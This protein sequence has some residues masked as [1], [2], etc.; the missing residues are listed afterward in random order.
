MRA[1]GGDG[2]IGGKDGAAEQRRRAAWRGAGRVVLIQTSGREEV[3]C[4]AIRGAFL[5]CSKS[6]QNSRQLARNRL[7][8]VNDAS[9]RAEDSE[10]GGE[11]PAGGALPTD[12][13]G[14]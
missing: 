3:V 12:L 14:R 13:S 5:S 8:F 1:G 4:S 9:C 10:A 7:V 6:H 11:G 2:R